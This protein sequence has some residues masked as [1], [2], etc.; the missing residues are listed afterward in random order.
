[1]TTQTVY[2]NPHCKTHRIS[3]TCTRK[4]SPKPD[5]SRKYQQTLQGWSSEH[6]AKELQLA[7][8][9]AAHHRGP[10]PFAIAVQI[11]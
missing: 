7:L 11:N 3:R 5:K 4:T 2:S 8:V 10:C 9:L 6:V 1:M